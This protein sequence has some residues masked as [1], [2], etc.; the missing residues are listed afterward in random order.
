MH[1]QELALEL[2]GS[3][4]VLLER[5]LDQKREIPFIVSYVFQQFK[6]CL[7]IPFASF[8]IIDIRNDTQQILLVLFEQADPVLII[9]GQKNFWPSAHKHHGPVLVQPL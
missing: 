5:R 8:E 2:Q 7:G 3:L 4:L 6:P 1:V 9:G